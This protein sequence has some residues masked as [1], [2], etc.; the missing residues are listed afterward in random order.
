MA[1]VQGKIQQIQ[2]E[3]QLEAQATLMGLQ[4]LVALA[5]DPQG[6]QMLQQMAQQLQQAQQTG[7][8]VALAG[9]GSKPNPE[10]TTG[11]IGMEGSGFA[12]NAA[13][14]S[15]GAGSPPVATGDDTSG[16]PL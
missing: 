2:A 3:D 4:T 9:Q 1:K 6:A 7:T 10:N 16:Q 12:S 15:Q 14:F 13:T 11:I 8:P 5:Q